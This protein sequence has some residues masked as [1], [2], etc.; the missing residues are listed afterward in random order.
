MHFQQGLVYPVLPSENLEEAGVRSRRTAEMLVDEAQMLAHLFTGLVAD[1]GGAPLAIGK[2]S[3]EVLRICGENRGIGNPQ[4]TLCD[5]HPF[6]D[7]SADEAISEVGWLRDRK[8]TRL[9]SSH[10][11]ISYAV[12]C[13]KKNK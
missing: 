3:Y 1:L 4:H 6:P 11:Q 10:S 8:S 13:L 12:F 5:P 9:N 2:N 7:L